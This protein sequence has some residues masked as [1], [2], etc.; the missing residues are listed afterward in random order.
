MGL[1]LNADGTIRDP[2][3]IRVLTGAAKA[4]DIDAE[5][6]AWHASEDKYTLPNEGEP[7]SAWL[8]LTETEYAEFVKD[9]GA[10][11]RIVAERKKANDSRRRTV[12]GTPINPDMGEGRYQDTLRRFRA[13]IAAGLRNDLD[14]CTD[15]GNKF[16]HAAWGLCSCK[17]IEAYP[18]VNDHTFPDRIV[19]DMNEG[20]DILLGPRSPPAGATCPFDR[21]L[22]KPDKNNPGSQGCFYRCRMFRPVPGTLPPGERLPRAPTR[23]EA[24]KLYDDLIAAREAKFGRKT[25]ADD[26]EERWEPKGTIAGGKAL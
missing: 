2:F 8:G 21:G 15:S 25:T 22:Q 10:F 24:L 17:D 23:E 19:D 20:R 14:D 7:L 6:E 26:G 16:T 5:I 9:A 11:K 1:T 13:R 18:D 3:I 4:E 12:F